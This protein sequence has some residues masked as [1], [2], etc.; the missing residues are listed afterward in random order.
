MPKIKSNESDAI[1]AKNFNIEPRNQVIL[2]MGRLHPIKGVDKLISAF[3]KVASKFPNA[4]LV[5]A[6]PD[7]YGIEQEFIKRTQTSGLTQRVRFPGMVS[8]IRKTALLHRADLF[9]LPSDAEGFSMAILEA[10]AHKTAVLISPRC[11]FPDVEKFGAGMIVE[12]TTDGVELGLNRLLSQPELL[13]LMGESGHNLVRERYT[14]SRVTDMM[15]DAYEEGIR[16]F[17]WLR[18]C[19]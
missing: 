5:L 10:L 13:K 11:F 9:C 3:E 18:N 8:D 12:A 19:K 17:H 2:F 1:T 6:G 16:R 14:W 15:I 4:L 7:E